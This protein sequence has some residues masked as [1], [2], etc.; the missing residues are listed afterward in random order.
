MCDVPSRTFCISFDKKV[1]YFTYY[2]DS[3]YVILY[4]KETLHSKWH[5]LFSITDGGYYRRRLIGKQVLNQKDCNYTHYG[6]LNN[7]MQQ[8]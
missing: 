1:L 4:L 2:F 3:L 8:K 6:N 5:A 7:V